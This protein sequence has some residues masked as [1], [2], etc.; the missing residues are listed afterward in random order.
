MAKL[1]TPSLISSVKWLRNAPPSWQEKAYQDLYN[2]LSRKPWE[3]S[4]AIKRGMKFEEKVN[5]C[6][7]RNIKTA[8]TEKF[9]FFLNHG[10]DNGKPALL[11]KKTK[12]F[13]KIDGVDYCLYG[14][15]DL[16]FPDVIKDIK[17]TWNYKE[18]NYLNSAQ[19]LIYCRGEKIKK[20]QY[21]IGVFSK[22]DPTDMQIKS[23][24]IVSFHVQSW[25]AIDE[26]L[27]NDIKLCLDT[28][29]TYDEL[30]ELYHSTFNKYG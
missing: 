25:E 20:F 12:S 19:H 23:T 2:A 24:H 26:L 21:L 18:S 28:F 27:I 7:R 22:D 10:F 29:E 5:Q 6:I 4:E 17:T 15:I 1:I 3:P 11:Q 30:K 13:I 16:W 8:G 14:R 9:Q